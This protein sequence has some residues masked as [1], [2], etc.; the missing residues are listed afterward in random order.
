MIGGKFIGELVRRTL[1]YLVENNVF[2]KGVITDHFTHTE[3]IKGSD[4]SSVE[5]VTD[6]GPVI[7]LLHRLGYSSAQI[8]SDD[9]AIVRYICAL[10]GVRS[11]LL[12]AASKHTIIFIITNT[13]LFITIVLFF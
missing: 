2:L 8:S 11:A 12:A 5:S 1:L 3:S 7:A 13:T 4:V 10:V 9:I 6:D